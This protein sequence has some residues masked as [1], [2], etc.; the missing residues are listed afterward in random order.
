MSAGPSVDTL[1]ESLS[2]LVAVT[3]LHTVVWA[4]FVVS[5]VALFYAAWHSR[6]RRASALSLIIWAET[7]VLVLNQWRCPLTDLA[8]R[9]TP[10]RTVAFDIYLPAFLARN[11]KLIFGSLFL[12]SQLLLVQRWILYASVNVEPT[13]ARQTL[14]A[15]SSI[16][17]LCRWR[18]RSA[19]C[20]VFALRVRWTR[21]R[22]PYQK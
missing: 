11:N 17:R 7:L 20:G 2:V 18:A 9:Y 19:E 21:R 8:A 5:L 6:L 3:I 1:D 15:R 16:M 13:T 22:R 14:P 10:D 12:L 4:L